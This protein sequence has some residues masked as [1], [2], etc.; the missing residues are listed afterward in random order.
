MSPW[1][2]RLHKWVGLILAIQFVLWM[3]SGVVMS[4]LDANKVNGRE[5]RVKPPLP[6]EWPRGVL[7][8]DAVLAASSDNVMAIA[9]G[10]L[11]GRP[12]YRLQN[13]K[14]SWLVNAMDGGPVAINAGVAAQIAHASY[15]GPGNAGTPRLLSFTLE[16]RAHKEA[17]WRVDFDDADETSVYVSSVSG[18][19]LEHRNST[20]RLFDLFWMLHI[21]DYSERTN[22]NNPL[23]VSSA[24]GGLW[25]ALTGVWLLLAS[26]RLAEFVPR[27][28]R[29]GGIVNLVDKQGAKQRSI[30]AAQGDTVFLA[31]ARSGLQLPSNCGGGQSCG[32]CEVRCVGK[33]PEPTSADRALLSSQKLD[34]G[35]RLA[36]GLSVKRNLDIDVGDTLTLS[37][38][39]AGVVTGVKPV[40]PFLREIT[41]RPDA[42]F[43]CRSGAYVQVHVPAYVREASHVDVP[44][45]H[46]ADWNA[47]GP[48]TELSS[49][50][51]LRRSYSI[52][53]P[54]ERVDGQLT[55]LV[56]F[57][58]GARPGRGSGYMYT[59][60][61][62]DAVRFSGPFG[63]FALKPGGREKVFIGGGAGMAPLRAMIHELLANNASEPLHFW[64]GAR[65]LRDAPYVDEMRG[66]AALHPN[67]HWHLVLSEEGGPVGVPRFVHEAV[68]DGLLRKHPDISSLEFYVCGPPAMLE[69]TRAMLRSLAVDDTNIAYDDFKI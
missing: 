61:V 26:V 28:W 46:R 41:I 68:L 34:A 44:P 27:R 63:D 3:S 53:V 13:D 24:I 62:G 50:A 39:R 2:R 66:F 16:T 1:M 54:V 49:S 60:K 30:D 31:L 9:S 69:A 12:V 40:T 55:F 6:P 57:M 52:A 35:F 4:L 43:E 36:C 25:M 37:S 17:V 22:F 33:A 51:A 47:A 38:E 45:D 23:L 18:A 42:P 8:A 19:V 21:M 29:G 5:F 58:P 65:T 10:W 48:L 14:R 64:Y 59:L 20:W 32:L 56:R 15:S 11:L 67:F 7:T